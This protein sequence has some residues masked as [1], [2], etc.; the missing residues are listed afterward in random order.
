[1]GCTGSQREISAPRRVEFNIQWNGSSIPTVHKTENLMI[2]LNTY[3]L[4][5]KQSPKTIK[6][7][8]H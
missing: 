3:N 1:M 2:I 6:Y 7:K 8:T 4:Y 5:T